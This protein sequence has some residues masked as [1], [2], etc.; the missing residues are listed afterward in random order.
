MDVVHLSKML[1]AV[2]NVRAATARLEQELLTALAVSQTREGSEEPDS[3]GPDEW[4]TQ[5][6]LADW[7][8]ISRTT[9]WR[10]IRESHIPVHRIGRT[11]RVR[12]S[13]VERWLIEEGDSAWR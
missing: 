8:K 9:V 1:D 7:L 4:M 6:E 5:E 10:L 12:R 3:T 11:V 2:R 13:D